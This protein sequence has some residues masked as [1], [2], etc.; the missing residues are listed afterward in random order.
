MYKSIIK[1]TIVLAMVFSVSC[2][3]DFLEVDNRN[4]LTDENFYQTQEDFWMALN[5]LYTPLAHGG[6]YGLEMQFIFGSFEDRILFETPGMDM[7]AINASTGKVRDMYR[8]LY[9]GVYRTNTF[10][11]KLNGKPEIEGMSDEMRRQY[12]AQARA[13][14][15]AYNYFLVTIFNKPPFYDD[16]TI[17]V[18]FNMTPTNGEPQQFWNLI[19]SDLEYARE[20]LPAVW[21]S[22]DKGRITRGAANALLGKAMLFKHYHYYVRMGAKGSSENSAD[23]QVAKNA[24]E[25]VINSGT[26]NLIKPQEPK[27]YK[28]YTFALL[29]NS[30]FIDLPSENN[31]YPSKNNQ[32]SIWEIQ[33]SDDR[34]GQGWLPG[35][36]WSGALNAQYFSIHIDSFRNH[37]VHPD[38]WDAFET[39]GAPDGFDRDPRAYATVYINGDMMDFRPESPYNQAFLAALRTK[40]VARARGLIPTTDNPY[41]TDGF[42]L[43]KYHFPVYYDKDAPRNDPF[44]RRMIRFAD[45]LLMYAE[46]TYLLQQNT[47]DGLAALNRVRARVDMPPVAALTKEAIIHE[48]DIELALEGHR[49]FDLIRW[50]FDPEWGINMQQILSRQTGPDGTG[51]FFVTGKHEFL[52]I[53]LR[54]INLSEGNLQQNPGW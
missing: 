45:V 36:M 12:F 51:S 4:Q 16:L 39:E 35:W 6:M 25:E 32:E 23:L 42:G 52:P 3:E 50:S 8:E 44:N 46:V 34:I 33:Y 30:S 20:H 7:L 38:L 5:S 49:W 17:P 40:R 10:I 11:Q 26:H 47:A 9:M 22:E 15:A 18:D 43:K 27:T 13:L 48:R 21:G 31:L 37:E 19:Q 54:E 53:P 14:R 2:S 24:F 41:P 1:F 29:S 28:D